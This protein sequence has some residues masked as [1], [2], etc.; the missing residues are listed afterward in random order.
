M[1]NGILVAPFMAIAEP[2]VVNPRIMGE[3]P[4]PMVDGGA[5]G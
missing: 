4:A 2:M 3:L 1:I 5:S